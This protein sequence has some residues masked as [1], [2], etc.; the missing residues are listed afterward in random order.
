MFNVN[1]ITSQ[2]AKMADPMLQK[3]AAMHKNDPYTVALAVGESNRRKAIRTA[4]Q[5]RAAGQQ[6]PKVVDRDIANMSGVDY[7]DAMGNMMGVLP[8]D[9]GIG[10]LPAPNMAPIGKAEGGIIGYADRGVV[11]KDPNWVFTSALRGLFE[12]EGGE[13]TDQGGRTKYGISSRGHPN[14]DMDKLTLNDA[15]KIYKRDYWDAYGLDKLAKRN[16]QLAAATFDTFVNHPP[17]FAKRALEESGGDV[18]KLLD[19][20][21]G[22][23]ERLAKSD[24][25]KNAGS[26]KGWNNRLTHLASSVANLPTEGGGDVSFPQTTAQAAPTT[27]SAPAGSV[28]DMM[29]RIPTGGVPGAGPTPA[30]PKDVGFL[31]PE[32][33]EKK[34]GV[35][36]DTA[37]NIYTNMMAPTPLAPVSQLPKTP[38]YVSRA[39]Q[40]VAGLGEKLYNKVVPTGKISEEGVAA[41]Q[42]QRAA[43]KALE[44]EKATQLRL[45]PPA[46]PLTQ[47]GPPVSV[48]Q[49]GQGVVQSA[50]D[51]EKVR[52]ANQ[53]AD[54]L[55]ASQSAARAAQVAENAPS[56]AEKI[57]TASL[58][59]EAD[60]AARLAQAARAATNTKTGVATTQIPGGVTDLLKSTPIDMGDLEATDR[61][62]GQV[63]PTPEVKKI[64]EEAPVSD[65][66]TTSGG[67]AGLFKDP[68]FL[69]GMRLM[70]S[71]NPRFLGAAGEA[72]IGTVGDLAAAE[73]ASSESEYR[74]AMGKYYGAYGEAIERGAKEKNEVQL[75][76]KSAQEALDTWAKNNKMAL[77]QSPDL[78]DRMRDKYRRDAYNV[79]GIKMPTMAAGAPDAAGGGFKLLG[80]RP[81]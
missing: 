5:G 49:A 36:P 6:Q 11:Q 48:T 4:A 22:E 74:K 51:L 40:G 45:T 27:S 8:E 46:A 21:R 43:E 77:F 39:V 81:G 24:P 35:S 13:T 66:K 9:T 56:A 52:L 69:M 53:A 55:A 32:D 54:R 37:R 25:N 41:L 63:Q 28:Q 76:E 72:G 31:S 10:R 16:P 79:Y 67:L 68:A 1:Q 2:L 58:L 15:A 34:F 38:G 3:Y 29:S 75:A 30:A 12:R 47:G 26:L 61:S 33:I 44:A 73:K 80:V 64:E 78:Y 17:A 18:N 59:R 19:I 7:S 50:E 57:Q 42:A 23:Y 62:L 71:Q 60:E 14:V 65:G 70:A 20:R